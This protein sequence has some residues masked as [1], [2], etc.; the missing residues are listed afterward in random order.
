MHAASCLP[1]V[2]GA[3]Q[4]QG[5]GAL[6]NQGDLYHWDKTLIEGWDLI[7]KGIRLLDQSRIGPILVGDRQDL[8]D[9]PPVTALLIQNTNPMAVAPELR[10]VHEGFARDDLFV[11]VHEQFL[12]ETAKVADVV[13]PATMFL[14]H[15][16][17]Y[18]ASGHTR[19]QIARKIFEP[20]AECRPNHFVICELARAARR[21]GPSR[22]RDDRV[23][24]DRRSAA[25]LRL[26]GCGERRCGR[27]L[28]RAARLRH[29]PPPERLPHAVRKIPVQAGLVAAGAGPRPHAEAARPLRDHRRERRSASVPPGR[30]AGAQLPQH[31]LHRDPDLAAQGGAADRAGP[32]RR[33]GAARDRRGRPGAARQRRA[34]RSWSM[35][36]CATASRRASWWS[37]A[38]GRT[39]PSR[40]ASASTP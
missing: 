8:G 23:A 5:G 11:C 25:A 30:G 37:R 39:R 34:A 27:G 31:Q 32:S 29:R 40:R 22:L 7:D 9:G 35:P 18:Q 6:Y 2:T 21:A 16:D 3:W 1:V 15:D 14:E 17:V 12:T 10:K 36:C 4:Y 13:L 26:A 38:S 19:I 20:Y 28:G 24:A 33:R